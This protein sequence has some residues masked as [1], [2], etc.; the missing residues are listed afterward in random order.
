MMVAVFEIGK[1]TGGLQQMRGKVVG[2]HAN[3]ASF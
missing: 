3:I 1:P 2:A